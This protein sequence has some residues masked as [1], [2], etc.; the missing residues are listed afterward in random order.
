[1]PREPV[2]WCRFAWFFSGEVLASLD[3][4]LVGV[5]VCFFCLY[6]EI[7]FKSNTEWTWFLSSVFSD[8]S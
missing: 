4:R 2:Q 8:I 5:A 3:S 6:L 7:E 1:M